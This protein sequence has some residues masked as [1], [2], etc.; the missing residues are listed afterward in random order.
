[1]LFIEGAG[2]GM[3][4]AF[5]PIYVD[6]TLTGMPW[7]TEDGGAFSYH[8]RYIGP[9]GSAAISLGNVTVGS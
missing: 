4:A 6:F 3:S 2:Y 8:R 9:T 1:V 5:V 7:P